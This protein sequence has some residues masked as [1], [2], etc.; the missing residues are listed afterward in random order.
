MYRHCI[1]CK[2]DLASNEVIERFPIGRRLAF[3]AARGRLWVVCRHCYRWNL[4]PL[5]ERWEAIESCERLYQD[6]RTRLATDNIGLA[7]VADGTDLVR[8]GQPQRPEFAAWRYG[9]HLVK[10]YRRRLK[11]GLL[12]GNMISLPFATI[13]ASTDSIA[14]IVGAT[15]LLVGPPHF[16]VLY[17][18]RQPE[19]PFTDRYGH[20]RTFTRLNVLR[21]RLLRTTDGWCL[22]IPHSNGACEINGS[23]ARRAAAMILARINARGAKA[24][25]VQDAVREVQDA[26][27]TDRYFARVAEHLDVTERHFMGGRYRGLLTRAPAPMAIALEMLTNEDQERRVLEGELHELEAMWREAEEIA[28]ISDNLLLPSSVRRLFRRDKE[29][30]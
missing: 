8:I 25:V 5:D 20:S 28:A 22:Q 9:D 11:T 17:L 14:G 16:V 27:T 1:Y 2:S 12:F 3:D 21:T 7:R 13:A 6:T 29:T 10:Q 26:G 30:Q 18:S 24:P 23:S 19:G 15:L 4:T